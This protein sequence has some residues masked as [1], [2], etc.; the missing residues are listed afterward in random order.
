MTETIEHETPI[1]ELTLEPQ[2]ERQMP[3]IQAPQTMTPMAMLSIAVQ[4]GADLDRLQK[5]MDLQDRFEAKEARKAYTE[6]VAAFKA[7]APVVTKDKD[8]LQYGSRYSSIGNTVTT[9]NP[10]LS[11]FGLSA[12]WDVDQ[13]DA[14]EVTCILAHKAGHSESRK[15]K[16]SPDDT[17][18]KNALQ[19][20]K[21]TV[22]YLKLATFELVTGIASTEA[23]QDDDGNSSSGDKKGMPEP[24]FV[25][26]LAAID[27]AADL[28]S[29]QTAYAT[30]YRAAEKAKDQPAKTTFIQKKDARKKVLTK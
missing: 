19:Q 2:P 16:A 13:S 21:S 7:E 29:L 20:I 30:A 27:G 5:L 8:N 24:E 18:K 3:A 4:Q 15:I 14:I 25:D 9:I 28:A 11:K 22:T 17:G 26:H 6:A 1:R 10:T 12:S 23:N